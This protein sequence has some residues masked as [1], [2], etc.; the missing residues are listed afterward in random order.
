MSHQ[1]P[2][3]ALVSAAKGLAL[4][5]S[6]ITTGSL[7]TLSTSTLPGII[8]STTDDKSSAQTA[9][10]QF[11]LAYRSGKLTQ[12]PAELLSTLSFAFLA[13]HFRRDPFAPNKWTLFAGAAVSMFSVV[14]YTLGL[15]E[16][17]SEKLLQLADAPAHSPDTKPELEH[18]K[19]SAGGLLG[20]PGQSGEVRPAITPV[21]EFEPYE[22]SPFSTDE[23]ERMKVQK[24]LKQWEG[25]N[26]VRVF[27]PL[28]AGVLG[29]WATMQ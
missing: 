27:M 8:H 10:Q 5:A 29:M 12:L 13:Y 23:Y 21:E 25:R 2:S 17:A 14:P 15:M 7:L 4:S 24:M 6:F 28:V 16:Q 20:V 18:K 1:S 3:P 11:A 22:D 19:E 26:V 9:A